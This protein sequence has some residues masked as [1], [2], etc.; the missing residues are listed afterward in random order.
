MSEVEIV[1]PTKRAA[2]ERVNPKRLVLYSKPKAGKTTAI[3]ALD[4]CVIL[5]FEDGANFVEAMR[6]K[7]DN[8]STL[9]KVG[10]KIIEAGKPYKRLAVDTVT[11]LE[12]MCRDLALKM[13]KDTPIGKNYEGANVLMLPNGAGYLYLRMAVESVLNY[14]DTLADDIILLGHLKDKQVEIKGEL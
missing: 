9:R 2:V 5:D 12:D 1:L 6:I 13:Y 14:I 10:A 3:A 7:I 11:A 8:L 4:D